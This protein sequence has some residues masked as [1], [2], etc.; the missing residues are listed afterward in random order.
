MRQLTQQTFSLGGWAPEIRVLV[1]SQAAVFSCVS[2]VGEVERL[3]SPPVS[4]VPAPAP[5]P[6]DSGG[7]HTSGP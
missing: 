1:P 6:D 3:Q 5:P 4:L 2:T 7:T